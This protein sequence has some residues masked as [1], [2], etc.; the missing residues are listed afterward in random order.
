MK[1][2][3]SLTPFLAASSLALLACEPELGSTSQG[4]G[5]TC[6]EN[7]VLWTFDDTAPNPNNAWSQS[8]TAD[9]SVGL[10]K[11]NVVTAVDTFVCRFATRDANGMITGIENGGNQSIRATANCRDLTSCVLTTNCLEPS[12]A[13]LNPQAAQKR[14]AAQ[15]GTDVRWTCSDGKAYLADTDKDLAIISCPQ[16]RAP[17]AASTARTAC[18]PRVCNGSMRRDENMNCVQDLTRAVIREDQ[19]KLL[20]LTLTPRY[21]P[22]TTSTT[23]G[24]KVHGT[25]GRPVSDAA[26][27]RRLDNDQLYHVSGGLQYVGVAPPAHARAALWL[28]EVHDDAIGGT[29]GVSRA[30]S[31]SFRCL[32]KT[33]DVGVRSEDGGTVS[34]GLNSARFEDDVVIPPDCFNEAIAYE[35]Q[36]PQ[37]PLSVSR[38]PRKSVAELRMHVSFDLE[39]T[40]NFVPTGK[41]QVEACGVDP[42]EFFYVK[43]KGT[44]DFRS[45]YRQREIKPTDLYREVPRPGLEPVVRSSY[46]GFFEGKADGLLFPANRIEMG[47]S[48]ARVERPAVTIR[49]NSLAT[50][51]I[52]VSGD[53]YIAL[54]SYEA[55]AQH[56]SRYYKPKM[57][58]YLVP[59]SASGGYVE[60]RGA[61]GFPTIGA[62]DLPGAGAD[63]RPGVGPPGVTV[64]GRFIVDP[65][66][67]QK[68]LSPDSML[69]VSEGQRTF[70][71][72]ACFEARAG[73]YWITPEY[74]RSDVNYDFGFLGVTAG[75]DA[76]TEKAFRPTGFPS[77]G[78]ACRW[79]RT[80]LVVSIDKSIGAV[81]PIADELWQGQASNQ[82]GG[83]GSV[84]Q[85]ND[86][87]VDRTCQPTAGG[88]ERCEQGSGAG[89]RGQGDY[90]KSYYAT[91]TSSVYA[92]GSLRTTNG[93]PEDDSASAGGAEVLGYQVLD[94][95]ADEDTKQWQA[96]PVAKTQKVTLTITPP[97]DAIWQAI[98]Q[99]NQGNPNPE[100][101]VGRY[102]GLMGLGV[103]WGYK[104]PVG[105]FGLVTFTVSV[106]FSLALVT[107]VTHSTEPDGK[108]QCIVPAPTDGTQPKP[109]VQ[110][111]DQDRSFT[112]AVKD[113]GTRGAR[114]AELS[115]VTESAVVSTL[116]SG[117]NAPA[118]MWVGA[119]QFDEYNP[120]FCAFT[121]DETRCKP[122]HKTGYRWLSNDAT[123][124]SAV[125]GTSAT[126]D[127]SQLFFSGGVSGGLMPRAP[128]KA[129]VLLGADGSI[130]SEPISRPH[131]YACLYDPARSDVAITV[132]AAIELGFAAGVGI[133][134]C[135]PTDELGVCLAGTLNLVAMKVAPTV[136]T[137]FHHLTDHAGRKARRDNTNLYAEWGITLLEGAV[138]A[139]FKALIFE[140]SVTL[141]EFSGFKLDGGR[142]Y[143]FN[144]PSMERF[145]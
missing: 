89:Q 2:L 28:S 3:R 139:K 76:D 110:L 61:E 39:D 46:H 16:P 64:N 87:D 44:Y 42:L 19:L 111:G 114:L 124:A 105:S 102:A 142:L 35:Q 113:C 69:Y 12:L 11:R 109:C 67:K 17:A 137:T 131:P 32:V 36:E 27:D 90:G 66:L 25:T 29:T 123:F 71:V 104:Q 96:D 145:R 130:S 40:T 13:L 74:W 100:W 21:L 106:G 117:V 58:V 18:V 103:G 49:V 116:L 132:S 81:E 9:A 119:Q 134:W 80:P 140:F 48:D 94:P 62:I 95:A 55:F 93:M 133:E 41:T 73:D 33:F 70:E 92:P 60:P 129:G 20:P 107:S 59:R 7:Q 144:F 22:F 125:G 128:S 10:V 120:S 24:A 51:T 77:P 84:K 63:G 83:N 30:R 121:W 43:D 1:T 4:V 26:L 5:G 15:L 56:L 57:R 112:D 135:Y 23:N 138:E 97:W 34:A 8:A 68:F 115:N 78:R 82:S 65:N 79:S 38:Y 141:V 136:E 52:S 72:L 85:S 88:G 75:N 108:Y 122:R 14:A 86:N 118:P 6:P 53:W 98:Q 99:A 101:T 47:L 45:Y 37:L 31:E 54:D 126:I 127:A 143:D 50:Q 91:S